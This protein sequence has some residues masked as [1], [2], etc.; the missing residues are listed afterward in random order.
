MKKLRLIYIEWADAI[1][2]SNWMLGS[3]AKDWG[4]ISNWIVRETGWLIEENE[5]YI[6]LAMGH[7]P[8]DETTDEQFNNLIKIPKPWIKRRVD[9]TKFYE[10]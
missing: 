4:K 8:A 9:L 7:K 10:T 3:E 5:E 1:R 2:N 6:I